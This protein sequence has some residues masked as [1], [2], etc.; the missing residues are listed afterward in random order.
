MTNLDVAAA[1]GFLQRP[2]A[3][4]EGTRT[5]TPI[6]THRSWVFL[7]DA[8]AYK[9]KKPIHHDRLD[10]NRPDLRQRNC[11]EEVRL[12]RRLA[13]DIYLGVVTLTRAEGGALALEGD[14]EPIDWLVQMRRLPAD[15]MLDA[16]LTS[17]RTIDEEA[18]I[19]ATARYLATFLLNARVQ[20]IS[21]HAYRDVLATGTQMD[22]DELL[23]PRFGLR[24]GR[25]EM[26]GRSQL[27]FLKTRSEILDRRVDTGR[28]IDGHGDL[29]PEHVC[30][31]PTPAFIDCLEFDRELRVLDPADEIAFLSLE[32]ERLG[33]PLV[34]RWFGDAYREVT[35]DTPPSLLVR[36]YRVY[37]ALR[38]A[39]IAVWHLDDPSVRDVDRFQATARRYLELVEPA[40]PDPT[41]G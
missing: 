28:I 30:V 24:R 9:L 35:G 21:G 18:H 25:V 7:T 13:P 40:V 8:F 16:I 3:Y 26:L 27:A 36:F 39:K 11:Y 14:G 32:C 20:P 5:V 12:N 4:P 17:G 34:G 1:V 15:G 19:R 38:R 37:R 23:E 6:E 31:R 2:E 33:Q 10:L 41:G 29:R 22:L